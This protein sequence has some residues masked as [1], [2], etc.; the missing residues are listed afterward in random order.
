MYEFSIFKDGKIKKNGNVT[1]VNY[2]GLKS[3]YY[4]EK[5]QIIINYILTSGCS[6]IKITSGDDVSK[7]I[8]SDKLY[9]CERSTW[10]LMSNV[11][12]NLG[13]DSIWLYWRKLKFI[14]N[15][16]VVFLFDVEIKGIVSVLGMKEYISF[17]IW[18]QKDGLQVVFW[19]NVYQN[20][21]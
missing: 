5:I 8:S 20:V 10:F 17:N 13:I 1:K 16:K 21:A 14:W 7:C 12:G 6:F 9:V 2:C 15:A 4:D 11:R 18:F 19:L 3:L